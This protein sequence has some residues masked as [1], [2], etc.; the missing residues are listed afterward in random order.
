M[1]HKKIHTQRVNRILSFDVLYGIINSIKSQVF[2]KLASDS[3]FV[4]AIKMR[5][6]STLYYARKLLSHQI[7]HRQTNGVELNMFLPPH[8]N[9]LSGH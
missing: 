8:V 5:F 1:R 9:V 6:L 7:V 3:L 4:G 2:F